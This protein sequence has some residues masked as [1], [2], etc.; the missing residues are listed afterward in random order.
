[1]L[2]R[3][4]ILL[5]LLV[6]LGLLLGL[7]GQLCRDRTL[8]L[9]H[10]FHIPLALLALGA[11]LLDILFLGRCLPRPRFALALISLVVAL[12]SAALVCGF[13]QGRTE[14][15]HQPVISLVQWNVH[16]GGG[17]QRNPGTWATIM[18][19]IDQRSPDILVLS[20]APP[21]PDADPA[22][23]EEK[24]WVDQ[25]NRRHQWSSVQC[26]NE[27]GSKYWYRMVVSSSGP[28]RLERE[29][30]IFNGYAMSVVITLH[31]RPIRLL[32]VDGESN[33][34]HVSRTPML[35]E[36]A[37]LCRAGQARGEPVDVILGDFNTVSRSVGFDPFAEM[38]GGYRLAATASLGWRGTY[39][40]HILPY[41]DIDHVWLRGEFPVR[42]CEFF[43]STASDHRGQW[44]QFYF[45]N[46][47]GTDEK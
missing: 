3:L 22:R 33:V 37:D 45:P 25:L 42:S 47:E 12:G 1:M 30:P 16:F 17:R 2:R 20:E 41:Y 6:C 24:T 14:L 32:V 18:E 21:R 39:Q 26:A 19:E 36:V 13:G 27:P 10:L 40:N 7:I 43:A 11:L 4:R 35:D 31:G 46:R 28:V 29:M 38:A 23:A 8:W 9:S 5:T 44:V 15:P 34:Q